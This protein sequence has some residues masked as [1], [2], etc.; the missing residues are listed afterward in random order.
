MQNIKLRRSY[1]HD[2]GGN[3]FTH[4]GIRYRAMEGEDLDEIL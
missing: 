3:R 4:P 2:S 1:Q